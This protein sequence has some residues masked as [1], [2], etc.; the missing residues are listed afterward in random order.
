[1]PTL[2]VMGP[3]VLIR[4]PGPGASAAMLRSDLPTTGRSVGHRVGF[5]N[6]SRRR[7]T[8]ARPS[9]Q[10][11]GTQAPDKDVNGC[12]ISREA[13]RAAAAAARA[14]P[15]R[16]RLARCG[17]S[18][19]CSFVRPV[20][21]CLLASERSDGGSRDR[22]GCAEG[23][24]RSGER[25]AYRGVQAR[26]AAAQAEDRAATGAEGEVAKRAEGEVANRAEVGGTTR[27]GGGER[28]GGVPFAG[29]RADDVER[30][31]R[32]AVVGGAEPTRRSRSRRA[33]RL[34]LGCDGC[35]D[36]P[37]STIA[38]RARRAREASRG[39][40]VR[41]DRDVRRVRDGQ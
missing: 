20:S 3:A 29:C 1:M 9:G 35:V 14:S 24:G 18:A 25:R 10:E 32:L 6:R 26:G 23:T 13:R 19:V 17:W 8:A 37:S 21:S 28:P 4:V 38:H 15:P 31:R 11:R 36:D 12:A 5:S 22:R 33:K 30:R 41:R 34:G 2:E 39:R 16:H 27:G 40:H 7:A